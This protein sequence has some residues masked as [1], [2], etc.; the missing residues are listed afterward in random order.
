[1]TREAVAE[2]ELALTVESVPEEVVKVEAV[3]ELEATL[4]WKAAACIAGPCRPL[5]AALLFAKSCRPTR[6]LPRTGIKST[7]HR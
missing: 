5:A 1:M 2:L 3:L 7:R 6:M 4:A